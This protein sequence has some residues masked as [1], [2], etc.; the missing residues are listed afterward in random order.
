MADKYRSHTPRFVRILTRVGQVE[1]LA[2]KQW[3]AVTGR[4]RG[5][6]YAFGPIS[7]GL[8]P[9]EKPIPPRTFENLMVWLVGLVTLAKLGQMI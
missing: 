5:T 1:V 4:L 2:E 6:W 7:S 3:V 9:Y 8:I